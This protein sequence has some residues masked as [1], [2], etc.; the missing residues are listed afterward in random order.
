MLEDGHVRKE[1]GVMVRRPHGIIL[2]GSGPQIQQY[3]GVT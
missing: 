2:P 1:L 3:I